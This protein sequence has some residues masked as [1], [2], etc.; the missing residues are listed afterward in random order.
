MIDP[1]ELNHARWYSQDADAPTNLKER[2]YL[3][4]LVRQRWL[5]STTRQQL[6]EVS[7]S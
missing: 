7:K 4:G 2:E 1:S 3:D 6:L 5:Q